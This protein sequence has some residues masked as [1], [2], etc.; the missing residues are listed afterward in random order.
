IELGWF[1]EKVEA[2]VR[3]R[4]GD[5]HL[6]ARKR[7]ALYNTLVA[8]P[9]SRLMVGQHGGFAQEEQR[10]PLLGFGAFA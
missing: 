1:G 7:V 9:Q 5:I 8:S 2:D 3:E 6:V 4:I 10:I